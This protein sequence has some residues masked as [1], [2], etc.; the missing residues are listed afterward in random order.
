V[1]PEF[2]CFDVR[3][4][5]GQGPIVPPL[6]ARFVALFGTVDNAILLQIARN[7]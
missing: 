5:V 2:V 1:Y 3:L 7:S 4:D 6:V